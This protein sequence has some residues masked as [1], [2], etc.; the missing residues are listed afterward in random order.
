MKIPGVVELCFL[1]HSL[2]DIDIVRSVQACTS[3]TCVSI[4]VVEEES[5][6]KFLN[7]PVL[8]PFHLSNTIRTVTPEQSSSLHCAI[9]QSSLP[10]L[11]LPQTSSAFAFPF[12]SGT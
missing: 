5:T 9:T 7:T 3:E 1:E 6:A 2:V 4:S 10:T 12:V 11:L 8:E